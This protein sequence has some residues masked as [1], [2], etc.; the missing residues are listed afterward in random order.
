MLHSKKLFTLILAAVLSAGLCSCGNGKNSTDQKDN[1]ETSVV[2]TI[3]ET[4]L[5]APS[6]TPEQ[7]MEKAKLLFDSAQ[8]IADKYS[9]AG[10]T[11][12]G[13]I[14]TDADLTKGN[15]EQLNF[16]AM[17]PDELKSS[18]KWAFKM[19]R[20]EIISAVYSPEEGSGIIARYPEEFTGS[21]EE[22]TDLS[23]LL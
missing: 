4:E 21:A 14:F 3:P 6:E 9:T 10:A 12:R 2:T 22:V 18:G 23:S 20:F 11:L 19:V 1:V 8:E 13:E 7:A 15:A 17:L 16:L 5:Q